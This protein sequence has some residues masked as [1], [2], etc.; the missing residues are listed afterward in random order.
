MDKV[1]KH[2]PIINVIAYSIENDPEGVKA[3]LVRN[4]VDASQIKGKTSLRNAF[5]NALAKSK[6][7]AIDFHRY[8][9][10]KMKSANFSNFGGRPYVEPVTAIGNFEPAGINTE[11]TGELID[12]PVNT[13]VDA[14]SNNPSQSSGGFFSGLNLKDLINTGVNILEIQRDIQVSKDT[15][16]AVNNAVKVKQDEIKFQPTTKSNNTG[17][18]IALG[19]VGVALVGGIIYFAI[20]KK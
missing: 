7:V 15:K 10:Q 9:Q 17:L 5:I 11:I 1:N 2:Q 3:V 20:K 14:P 16:D 19:F 4:G 13:T 18:F 6:A 12:V 8:L